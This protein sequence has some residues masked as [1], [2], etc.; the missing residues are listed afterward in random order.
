MNTIIR[1]ANEFGNDSDSLDRI[2]KEKDYMAYLDKH[3]NG[4][5]QAYIKYFVPLLDKPANYNDA[6]FSR[7]ELIDAIISVKQAVKH[8]DESKY[9]EIEFEPYRMHWN[10]TDEEKLRGKEYW[11]EVDLRY[12]EAW[13]NH[14]TMNDH[15]PK[16]WYDFENNVAGDMSLGAIIHM[17][18]DWESFNLDS[19]STLLKWYQKWSVEEHKF[20]S[21]KTITIT[22]YILYN[23]LH[24]EEYKELCKTSENI[25]INDTNK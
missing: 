20:M 1:E 8:H 22:E 16:H 21:P 19:P 13:V 18:C 7:D 4:V 6:L 17:I 24:P 14:Y 9:T 10:P 11:D 2:Q 25:A 3:I 5:K 12:Q 23:I 15:H